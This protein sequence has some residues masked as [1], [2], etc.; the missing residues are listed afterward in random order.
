MLYSTAACLGIWI[1][2]SSSVF[3]VYMSIVGSRLRNTWLSGE[4]FFEIVTEHD[5]QF[6]WAVFSAI[7]KHISQS[8][9]LEYDL[10]YADGYRG[11]LGN[12]ISI[13]H[14]L[15]EIEIVPWDSSLVLLI[16]KDNEVID[17]FQK[18][19]PLSEDL[20]QYN[21]REVSQ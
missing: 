7:P 9:V 11:F 10:P 3:R 14:P 13:Q 1:V 17:R 19:F 5:I 6:I 8:E 12:P 18:Q 20:E 4:D 2:Q 15:A 16:S 21:A